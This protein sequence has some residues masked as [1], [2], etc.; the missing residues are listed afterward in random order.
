MSQYYLIIDRKINLS[1][2]ANIYDYIKSVKKND[3]VVIKFRS[4][5]KLDKYV[6][7]TLL[8]D[9]NFNIIFTDKMNKIGECYIKAM[10]N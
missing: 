5:N 1:D 10:K 8:K 9:N 7:S 2:Y 3:Q 4:Q 6:I